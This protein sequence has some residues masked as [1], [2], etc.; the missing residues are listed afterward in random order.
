M[1]TY[2]NPLPGAL[3]HYEVELNE[4]L[5][6]VGM[7]LQ[8]LETS[9]IEGASGV[10]GKSKMLT[11]A[12]AN[13]RRTRR[14]AV[15]SNIQI[16]PSLGLAELPL[17]RG[18]DDH[19]HFVVLHDPTPLR[20]QVGFDRISR[21]AAARARGVKLPRVIVHSDDAENVARPLLPGF[22]IIKLR[23]PVLTEVR[24]PSP[25]AQPSVLV[26]GQYKPTRDLRLLE[27][28]GPLLLESGILGRIVGRGWPPL[29]GWEVDSRF[30]EESELDQLL[31]SASAVLLPYQKYFQSGIG[32]RALEQ[33]TPFITGRTSFAMDV[34]GHDSKL[35]YDHE[36]P[37]S[38]RDAV[39]AAIQSKEKRGET[40]ALFRD[41]VDLDWAALPSLTQ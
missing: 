24:H 21:W 34:L 11:N 23:H 28:L 12:L 16:W 39:V 37:S 31:G 27:E 6:R 29:R 5:R 9:P 20:R 1:I 17:W 25:P 22:E 30:V 15:L 13:V 4:T 18:S 14:D 40:L 38:V 3:H 35:I 32:L 10:G 36:S 19:R 7:D 41:K 26:A 8:R 2:T 33:G